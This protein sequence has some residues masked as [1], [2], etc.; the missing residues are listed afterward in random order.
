[1]SDFEEEEEPR[2]EKRERMA[3]VLPAFEEV[4]N[5]KVEA[6]LQEKAK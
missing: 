4:Y 5:M 3:K 6:E 2:R 1:M